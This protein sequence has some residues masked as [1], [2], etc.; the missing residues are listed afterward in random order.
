MRVLKEV[1]PPEGSDYLVHS[2]IG[3]LPGLALILLHACDC[4]LHVCR[5]GKSAKQL[6][7]YPL[8]H[9]WLSLPYLQSLTPGWT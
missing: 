4:S 8:L 2:I 1:K 3:G 7:S 6:V 5:L 9:A